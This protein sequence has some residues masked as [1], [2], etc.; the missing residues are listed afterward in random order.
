MGNKFNDLYMFPSL[1]QSL[2]FEFVRYINAEF[3]EM[4]HSYILIKNYQYGYNIR[5]ENYTRSSQDFDNF[6]KYL[7]IDILN[8][9]QNE[10]KTILKRFA[11]ID[12]HRMKKRKYKS[13]N[14][15]A[16]LGKESDISKT[17]Q[18]DQLL[19]IKYV[20]DDL[21]TI[22]VC[23]YIKRMMLLLDYQWESQY[24]AYC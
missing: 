3:D 16:T 20:T 21:K 11:S 6:V 15:I 12:I 4:Y 7:M 22:H 1:N 23:K 18:I 19:K 17:D 2:Y 13:D 8:L 9:P 14:H 24:Q 10:F 5:M